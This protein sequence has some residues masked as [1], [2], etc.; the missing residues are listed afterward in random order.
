M[1][2][3]VFLSLLLAPFALRAEPL[4]DYVVENAA[5]IPAPLVEWSGGPAPGEALFVSAGCATCHE[6]EDAPKRLAAGEVRL[7]IVDPRILSP[8][9]TMPAYY[10]PGRFG[11]APD[12]LVGRTRLTALEIEQLVAYLTDD[13]R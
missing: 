5:A 11:D 8:E 2:R 3:T 4:A 1:L 13:E 9:T 6:G 12:A 7:W 10:A